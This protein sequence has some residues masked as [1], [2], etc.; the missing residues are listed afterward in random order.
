MLNNVVFETKNFVCFLRWNLHSKY[1]Q[2]GNVIVSFHLLS[3]FMLINFQ[4]LSECQFFSS[5]DFSQ[6]FVNK[7]VE[8]KMVRNYEVNSFLRFESLLKFYSAIFPHIKYIEIFSSY[9]N[10]G[11][12]TL[13]INMFFYLYICVFII[14]KW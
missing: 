7:W 1:P 5:A 10:R 9:R 2:C 13:D 8:K 4:R 14:E 12:A 6:N 3:Q 11:K